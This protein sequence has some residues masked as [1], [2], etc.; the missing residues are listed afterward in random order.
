MALILVDDR[1]SVRGAVVRMQRR[2]KALA[3]GEEKVRFNRLIW[4]T[5]RVREEA[6]CFKRR[7]AMVAK[8][9]EGHKARCLFLSRYP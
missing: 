5:W 3:A 7:G 4:A 6:R 9:A 8:A 2:L 1:S